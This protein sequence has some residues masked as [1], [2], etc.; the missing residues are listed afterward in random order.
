MPFIFLKKN[1]P[2]GFDF[3]NEFNQESII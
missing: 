2:F 3:G 1:A